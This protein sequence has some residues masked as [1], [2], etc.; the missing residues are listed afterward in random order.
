MD[1]WGKAFQSEGIAS[2]MALR[3][4]QWVRSRNYM[5]DRLAENTEQEGKR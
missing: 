2:G 4:L 5:E 3:P 1:I